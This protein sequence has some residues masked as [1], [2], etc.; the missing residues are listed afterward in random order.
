MNPGKLQTYLYEN[1]GANTFAGDDGNM[2]EIGRDDLEPYYDQELDL[3]GV[4]PLDKRFQLGGAVFALIENNEG[5][6]DYHGPTLDAIVIEPN[7][8]PKIGRHKLARVRVEREELRH[9]INDGFTV[10]LVD[11]E[12]G[13]VWLEFSQESDGY[14]PTIDFNYYPKSA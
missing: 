14:Y 8:F 5:T 3:Y 12:D 2:Y 9:Y 10:R 11:V 1:H 6:D 4:D 13:H 7:H